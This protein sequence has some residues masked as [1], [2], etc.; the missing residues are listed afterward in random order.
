MTSD[1]DEV[2]D[3]IRRALAGGSVR[4][5]ADFQGQRVGSGIH[6]FYCAPNDFFELRYWGFGCYRLSKYHDGSAGA[7]ALTFV[8]DQPL[9]QT[10]FALTN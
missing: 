5:T 9:T 7:I 8:L 2:V 3:W 1:F 4:E 10:E 6:R